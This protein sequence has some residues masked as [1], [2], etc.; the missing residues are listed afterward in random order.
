MA[1]ALHR[2][3]VDVVLHTASDPECH[4]A[5]YVPVCLCM[6]WLREA[7]TA[8]RPRIAARFLFCTLPHLLERDGA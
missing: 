8:R 7:A 3:G 1:E 2:D 4:P 5:E 6:D